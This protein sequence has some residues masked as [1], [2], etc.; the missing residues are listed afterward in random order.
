[1]LSTAAGPK[2]T[3]QKGSIVRLDDET[4]H[5]WVQSGAATYVEKPKPRAVDKVRE[6]EEATVTAPERAV[7]RRVKRRR[8][9]K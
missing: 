4:A 6:V 9:K 3:F 7:A 5:A 1:M 8:K 2:G